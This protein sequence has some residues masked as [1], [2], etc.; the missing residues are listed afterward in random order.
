MPY[1][2]RLDELDRSHAPSF[3]GKCAGLG[4]LL[5]GGIA[6][7]PGFAISTEAYRAALAGAAIGDPSPERIRAAPMPEAA[8]EEIG[9]RYA[10]LAGAQGESEPAV[11]VR[12]S[13]VGEDSAEAT[14]A[15]LQ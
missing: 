1:T 4:E 13:A 6:V 3:G 15:G 12:S 9:R 2:L 14:F 10:E 11:A 7:P 8:R 5:A